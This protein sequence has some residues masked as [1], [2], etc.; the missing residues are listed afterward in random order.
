MIKFIIWRN[1]MSKKKPNRFE[2]IGLQ[3]KEKREKA[4]IS[5]R[6]LGLMLGYSGGQFVYYVET[7]K[8]SIP[9]SKL[10]KWLSVIRL[11][12]HEY[13]N[14]EKN[15]LVKDLSSLLGGAALKKYGSL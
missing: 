10:K 11:D 7:G 14:L 9:R 6:D 13:I 1:E 5:Q 12:A 4:G 3:L 8:T 15:A 2:L